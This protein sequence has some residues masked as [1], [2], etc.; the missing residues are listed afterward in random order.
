MHTHTSTHAYTYKHTCIHIQRHWWSWRSCASTRDCRGS[1]RSA[2]KHTHIHA[3]TYIHIHT[4]IHTRAP[5]HTHTAFCTSQE[6][7]DAQLRLLQ[8]SIKRLQQELHA[9][10]GPAAVLCASAVPNAGSMSRRQGPGPGGGRSGDG[11]GMMGELGDMSN[12][13][14]E[15]AGDLSLPSGSNTRA[16]TSSHVA[17]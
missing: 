13:V 14:E 1:K 3:Y 4:Y 15:S 12:V 9:R 5:I 16:R 2:Y 10:H 6:Q 8:E 17:I 11:I 7:D